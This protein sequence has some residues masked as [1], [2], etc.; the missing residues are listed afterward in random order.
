MKRF[1]QGQERTQATLLPECLDDYVGEDSTVRVVDVFVDQ[2]DLRA[3]GFEGADPAATGRPSYHPAVLLKIYLYGYL[4]RVQSS[5]RL[6]REAQRNVEL[7]W[8]TGRLMPDFKTIADFRKDNG[9]AIRNVCRQFIVL[10]RK[11][12]LFSEA[13]V[14]I[15]GSKFKAVNNRDKNFTSAK[16][17]RRMAQ[18]EESIERYLVAMDTADRAEPEV[19]RLKKERL[20]E[21]IV[22]LKQQMQKLQKLDVQLQAS[23]DKQLSLTDPDAR[24]MKSRDGSV[25]GYNVQIAVDAKHHLIVAHEVINEGVDRDQLAPMSERAQDATGVETLTAVADRGYFKGEQIKKCEDAGVVPMVPKTVTSNSL[26][27]GRFDKQD[28]IYIA[29][30]DEYRCPAGQRA[31]KRFTTVEAGMTLDVYWSSACTHCPIKA[32]CTTSDYR[33]IR[34]W[35]HEAVLDA[36]QARLDRR[37]EMMRIRRR[38]VEHPFGTLKHWMGATHFLTRTLGRVRTE[39]SLHVLAYNLKRVIRILGIEELMRVLML[40][41]A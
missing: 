35:K 40:R 41:A 26:A 6:E 38:T 23:P 2:L 8:L 17:Q 10:C 22:A 4:N 21:K 5:R 39:M 13:L 28:F 18:I 16:M 33:R 32:Q 27:E 3:L 36:M 7:M 37:P 1:I 30:D 11:L 31:I 15:D 34:R 19:A 20:Q 14:A 25:V 9:P 29:A 12:D 24:S